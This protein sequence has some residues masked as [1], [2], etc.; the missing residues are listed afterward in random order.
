M[1]LKEKINH[2]FIAARKAH[3]TAEA[4]VLTMVRTAIRYKEIEKKGELTDSDLIAII[5]HEIKQR[6]DSVTQ[7]TAGKRADLAGKEKKEIDILM[8][9]LPAQ[10]SEK[11]IEVKI[12]EAVARSGATGPADMGKVMGLA[13]KDLKGKADG[14]VVQKLVRQALGT[15]PK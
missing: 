2:D 1:S 4:S 6:K 3:Q 10:L 13:M 5:S 8:K 14:A 9:Y 15:Q 7:F 11:Q 12:K